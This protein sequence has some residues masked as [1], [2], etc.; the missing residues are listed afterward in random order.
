MS[1]GVASPARREPHAAGTQESGRS[2]CGGRRAVVG[3]AVVVT[4]LAGCAVG[5]DF[6]KPTP[7]MPDAYRSQ[8]QPEE[9]TSFADL[10][11]W[12]VFDD[13]RLRDLIAEA[14]E[15]NYD[16][17]TALYRVE[18]AQHQVGITRS[19]IFPQASYQGGA[20]RGKVF[21]GVLPSNT[22]LNTFLGT[23]N[24]AWEIDVWGRI[25][26]GSEASVADL[27]ATEDFRRG[28]I[29]SLV[30]A[31]AQA[32]FEL[33]E[34]DLELQIS[35]A[36]T[37][38]F[39]QTLALFTRRFKGGVDSL[40]S[41][42]RAQAALSQTAATIPLLEQ[43]IVI[44]ENQISILLGRHP[45]PV[46]RAPLL[47]QTAVPPQ[48]PPG[49]PSELLRRRPDILQAEQ[50]IVATNALVG[51]SV[52]NFFPRIGLTALYGGQSSE[53]ENI[54]KGPGT[55]WAISG[56]VLGPL[57]TGGALIESYRQAVA[58]WEAT[59]ELYEQTVLRALGE[60]SN[61]LIAEQKLAEQRAQQEQAVTAYRESVRLA[62]LRYAGGLASYFEVLEAQQQLF[63]AENTLAQ[64]ERDQLVAVVQL[65]AA[66]GGGWEPAPF[67]PPGWL[68]FARVGGDAAST[69]STPLPAAADGSAAAPQPSDASN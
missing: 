6:V 19:E 52:A 47:T 64:I 40:L 10:R 60:V 39:T 69:S 34:L 65:Y 26:R 50:Q 23:F 12:E 29:L 43:Q 14:L 54:V 18:A 66:L 5:P 48:T 17:R 62:L 57:F 30:S 51:V 4:A 33:Q 49:V 68:G 15:N 3:L 67:A 42:N 44:K 32:Y 58:N 16:L 46:A 1:A 21:T 35:R 27:L 38:S 36:T 31:V 20:G 53:L 7:E 2:A 37:E 55:V 24:L 13:A 61:A 59:K 56:S 8:L 22:T 25:R 28:V 45:G 63:P 41:V 9:A 11:W